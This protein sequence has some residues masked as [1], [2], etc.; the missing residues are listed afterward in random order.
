MDIFASW[1][2]SGHDRTIFSNSSIGALFENGDIAS[3]HLLGD[4]G[5]VV[6]PYLMTPLLF[7]QQWAREALQPLSDKHQKYSGAAVWGVETSFPG[8][9]AGDEGWCRQSAHHHHGSHICPAE[10]RSGW[11]GRSTTWI[12]GEI[13][14]CTTSMRTNRMMSLL[15]QTDLLVCDLGVAKQHDNES[16]RTICHGK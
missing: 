15:F 5:Y 2:S 11:R 10:Y 6:K 1:Y 3:G 4:S 7:P 13:G 14:Q 8:I 9:K 12:R 16:F